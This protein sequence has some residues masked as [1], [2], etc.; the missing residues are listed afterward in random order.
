MVE[1]AFAAVLVAILTCWV[2]LRQVDVMND[3]L[4]EIR[5]GSQQNERLLRLY[6]GQAVEM[7][8]LA[9]AAKGQLTEMQKAGRPYL[10][11]RLDFR[12]S[13]DSRFIMG[14]VQIRNDSASP[15]AYI[16]SIP[17]MKILTKGETEKRIKECSISY[18]KPERRQIIAPASDPI[19]NIKFLP[20]AYAP[21]DEST[22][23]AISGRTEYVTVIGGIKYTGPTGGNFETRYCF[24]YEPDGKLH[25][26][27]CAVCNYTK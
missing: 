25:T 16:A 2:L 14:T 22:L 6:R 26:K 11:G 18:L 27:D 5:G 21:V 12:F 23:K 20:D 4:T 8:R 10:F 3:T 17:E 7:A 13:Q 24:V 1:S 9:G 15:A 19:D